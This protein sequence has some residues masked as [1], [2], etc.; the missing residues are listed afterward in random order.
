MKKMLSL[1]SQTKTKLFS[2]AILAQWIPG[3]LT[4]NSDLATLVNTIL[5][6]AFGLA[7]LIAVAYLIWGGYQYITSGGGE[8]AENGKKT[9]MNAI[10]GIIIIVAAYAIANFVWQQFTGTDIESSTNL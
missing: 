3:D 9:I 2:G 6:I 10:I 5:Q 1:F 8:G 7:G 4:R